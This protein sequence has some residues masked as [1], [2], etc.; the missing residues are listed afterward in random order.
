[1]VTTIVGGR[2]PAAKTRDLVARIPFFKDAPQ[3]LLNA[4]A[5]VASVVQLPAGAYFLREGDSCDQF[6]VLVSGRMRVFKLAESGHEITLYHVGGG[7]AC[8]LNVSCILSD[9][10]VPAMAQVEEDVEA[11]TLPAGDFRRLVG[12]HDSLRA[13]I[14]TMFAG[15]LAEVM[16]LVEEVAFR[17][18]DERVALRLSEKFQTGDAA[19]SG[20]EITHAE[21]A[22]ELGTAR[23]VVSRLLK[24]FER[25]GAIQLARGRI[26]L[27]DAGLL[28]DLA[29]GG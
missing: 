10:P 2:A 19:R 11:L 5:S 29:S 3:D 20:L 15:R 16:S 18:M 28:Q 24:D 9:R 1:M 14:F 25:L 12:E 17:R 7:E 23:E 13:F 4:V 22:S 8:P 21:L 26:M 27:R 6:A